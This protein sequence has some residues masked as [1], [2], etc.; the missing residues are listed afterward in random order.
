MK[1]EVVLRVARE[2]M[3]SLRGENLPIEILSRFYGE[4]A[5]LAG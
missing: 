2:K 4:K 1:K 5:M 3:L